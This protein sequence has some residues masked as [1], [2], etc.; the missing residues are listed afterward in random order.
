[1]R[2]KLIIFCLL[3]CTASLG[4]LW[5]SYARIYNTIGEKNL[6]S[7]FTA[8][9]FVVGN[10]ANTGTAKYVAMGDS[11]SA[12][13]GVANIEDTLVYSFAEH[14]SKDYWQ[15]NV[16]NL[17]WPGDE[18][19]DVL[20]SQL[21]QAIAQK[22]DYVTIFIGIN[23]IHEKVS[24]DDFRSNYNDILNQ[25]LVGTQAKITVINLPYLGADNLI[26]F[27][28]NKLLD[29]KTVQFNSIIVS[30]SHND[31]I[32][33]IDLYSGSRKTLNAAPENYASD[34]FHPSAKGYLLWS[35]ILNAD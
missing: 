1:M 8:N 33:Y 34:M 5:I 31:R 23:D 3:L 4:Y 9:N 14:L 16:V 11:L 26:R 6:A 28:F 21:P 19:I 24:L 2:I 25:L 12:G 10:S 30:L 29:L 20:K 35:K 17:A 32:K 18:S 22:P 27:P 13:V 7:P 15:V